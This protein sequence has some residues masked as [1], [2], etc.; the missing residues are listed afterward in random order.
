MSQSYSRSVSQGFTLIEMIIA[1]AISTII[2]LGTY[3]IFNTVFTAQTSTSENLT[4]TAIQT[5]L[6]KIINDDFINMIELT[7]EWDN[8]TFDN[9]SSINADNIQT[10]ANSTDNTTD[11]ITKQNY[12]IL[13]EL[14]NHPAFIL[15]TYNSLFFNK[16]VPVR[17]NYFIDKDNYLVRKEKSADLDFEKDIK[18]IGGVT[19]IKVYSFDGEKFKEKEVNPKL[20]RFVFIINN[21]SYEISAGKILNEEK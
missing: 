1:L 9:K 13:S 10:N 20:T 11:N 14:N 3:A 4:Y 6:F 17:V 8:A 15:D 18:L 12:I 2:V 5:K 16:A 7:S 21:H 19:D